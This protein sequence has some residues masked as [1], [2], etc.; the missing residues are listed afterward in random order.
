MIVTI[1]FGETDSNP[2]EPIYTPPTYETPAMRILIMSPAY[3][4]VINIFIT[5]DLAEP[6]VIL[7]SAGQDIVVPQISGIQIPVLGGCFWKLR[8]TTPVG[9]ELAFRVKVNRVA[10]FH[11]P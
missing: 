2:V 7:K 8:S 11:L 6:F 3:A 1:P 9:A 10:D 4:E 5:D